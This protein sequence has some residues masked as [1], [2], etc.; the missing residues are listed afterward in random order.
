MS[1]RL[2][3]RGGRV[4]DPGQRKD[5]IAD[6]LVEDGRIAAWDP[7]RVESVQVFNA[8]GLIIAPGLVELHAELREPGWE[9][10]ETIETGL[11]AAVRGGFTSVGCLPSTEPPID[12]PAGVQF[13]QAKA[14]QAKLAKAYVIACISQ[15]REGQQ[16]AEIG[17]LAETGAVA[18][19]DADR[20]VQNAALF[21]RALQYCQ[22]FDRPVLNFPDVQELSGRG[23]MHEGL[24]STVLGLPGIPSAAEDVMTGRDL[25]LAEATGGR[26]HLA[27]I[28]SGGSVEL[29]RK[30]KAR[31]IPV[32]ASTSIVHCVLTDETL[33]SFETR[34]KI[35]PPLRD[36]TDV[37]SCVSGLIDQTIDVIS[38]GHAPRAAEK[39]MLELDRAPF[40]M[41]GLETCLSLAAT[42]LVRT[43][44][45]EWISLLERLATAP[46]RVL[47]IDAGSLREGA[48]ADIV[49]I[50]PQAEWTVQPQQFASKCNSSPLNG[51]R[52]YG[53]VAVTWVDG[54]PVFRADEAADRWL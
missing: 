22:M 48:A 13:V 23:V 27:N 26:L 6:L 51:E 46:A 33:R 25:R 47:G 5:R 42:Y 38:S 11:R 10:D 17:G 37:E 52:L 54:H 39:K 32:T 12:T 16:L 9:E 14:R 41:S 44:R 19:S 36:S 7:G 20:P 2:L 40:G 29:I 4:I 45:L 18:F 15:N 53:Q 1:T 28:S 21:R 43:G 31:G 50:D 24:V 30:F 49:A 8:E 35:H 3:I 34:F